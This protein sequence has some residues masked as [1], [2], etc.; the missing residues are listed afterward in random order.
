MKTSQTNTPLHALVTLNDV[1]YIEAA[2]ALGERLLKQGGATDAE[3]LA[4]GFRLCTSRLPSEKESTVLA[5]S[6]ARF[7]QQYTADAAAAQ[8]LITIGE[9]KPDPNLAAPELAAHASLAL[10]FL[11]LDE[12][13]TKE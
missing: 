8:K 1:T 7:R 2:R 6:L 10:L 5:S 11:N 9:S 13:L 3:R 12:T 4:F